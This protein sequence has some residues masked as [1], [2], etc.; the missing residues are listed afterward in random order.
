MNGNDIERTRRRLTVF[1]LWGGWF[2]TAAI[3]LYSTLQYNPAEG[4]FAPQWVGF[5]FIGCIG[6]SIAAGVARGRQ[7]LSDTIVTAFRAGADAYDKRADER[8]ARHE[9]DGNGRA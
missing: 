4:E 3:F 2:T 9:E 7:T 8:R 1:L 5:T 6:V